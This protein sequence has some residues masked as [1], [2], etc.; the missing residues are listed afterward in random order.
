[1]RREPKQADFSLGRPQRLRDPSQ[2]WSNF[3]GGA[4]A[5]ASQL[6][7]RSIPG[8]L[9]PAAIA[10]SLIEMTEEAECKKTRANIDHHVAAG[11]RRQL[12]NGPQWLFDQ[13]VYCS[14]CGHCAAV[15]QAQ[16]STFT[17]SP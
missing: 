16:R 12:T 11:F 9:A 15:E 1:V 3:V 14:G 4:R 2:S 10:H 8:R 17:H 13:Q 5:P 6:V 7:A